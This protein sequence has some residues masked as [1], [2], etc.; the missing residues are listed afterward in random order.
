VIRHRVSHSETGSR[1][2][3]R[4]VLGCGTVA[5]V[6]ITLGTGIALGRATSSPAAPAAAAP[7]PPP[8]GMV[9]RSSPSAGA[10]RI[11]AGVPEGFADTRS[12][13]VG[14]AN[15]ILG[16]EASYLMAHPD[17][18]RAAWREMC[19]PTYFSSTGRAAAEGVLAG[20]E[21]NNHLL[22][23]VAAGQRVYE[24]AFPLSIVVLR[25][26]DAA[27]TVRTW[28]LVVAHPGDGPTLVSFDAGTLQLRWSAG[29]WRL[30][31]GSASSSRSEGASGPLLLDSGPQLPGYLTDPSTAQPGSTNG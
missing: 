27:A 22:T 18:Y 11:V 17:A 28:S 19:T 23:N 3:S 5:A 2:R 21:T 20:Q 15:A 26:T 4:A 13:A 14:A 6:V 1:M 31:G 10:T 12:G 29:N 25:Y 9:A 30:D 7:T 8:P 16:V 24:R